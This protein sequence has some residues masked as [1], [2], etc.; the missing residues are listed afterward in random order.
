MSELGKRVIRASLVRKEPGTPL[1]KVV[2]KYKARGR[3]RYV[4]PTRV[5]RLVT[6]RGL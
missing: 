1:P 4:E 5:T 6:M 3:Y 2:R